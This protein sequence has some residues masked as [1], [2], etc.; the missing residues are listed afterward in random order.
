MIDAVTFTSS[1]TVR[2]FLEGLALAGL[3]P[4]QTREVMARPAIICIGPSTAQT[5]RE[6]GLQVSAVAVEHTVAGMVAALLEWF[7][8]RQ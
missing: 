6:Q 1:S 4:E 7:A 8:N 5:A 2:Y 3:T